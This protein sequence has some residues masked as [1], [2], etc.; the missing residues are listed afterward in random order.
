MHPI[1]SIICAAE[2]CQECCI[3]SPLTLIST[4]SHLWSSATLFLGGD[5]LTFNITPPQ[6]TFMNN[7]FN[8]IYI[9]LLLQCCRMMCCVVTF[10]ISVNRTLIA[11]HQW[12]IWTKGSVP[13][14][15]T[16]PPSVRL[17]SKNPQKTNNFCVH[18]PQSNAWIL[19]QNTCSV[20]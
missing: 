4:C 1:D 15:L 5:G 7:T 19:E 6:T 11:K 12:G 18:W 3:R 9:F 20:M 10:M 17:A 14:M 2:I 8:K 13:L 16:A